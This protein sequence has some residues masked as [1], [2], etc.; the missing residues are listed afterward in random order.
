MAA[1]A[2][3]ICA[4]RCSPCPAT[5]RAARPARARACGAAGAAGA[6]PLLL[7]AAKGEETERA[8]VWLMRQA[9]RYMADFRKFSDK[10]PFRMRSET[11][12]IAVELSLQPYDGTEHRAR[13]PIDP[14][15]RLSPAAQRWGGG[16]RW[17]GGGAG[18]HA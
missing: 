2:R 15:R 1:A 11:S 5:P 12:E 16:Q 9:G 4:Q 7:R 6:E 14:H 18:R 3:S 8:P 13:R 10:Y 17:K